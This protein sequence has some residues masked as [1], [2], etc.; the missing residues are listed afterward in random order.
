[1]SLVLRWLASPQGVCR[2]GF[3]EKNGKAYFPSGAT[4][5]KRL[6]RPE[7]GGG[8]RRPPPLGHNIIPIDP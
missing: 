5:A 1:M 7:A 3:V 6:E 8:A 4:T 2:A